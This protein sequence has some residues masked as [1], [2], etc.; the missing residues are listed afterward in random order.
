MN[1]QVKYEKNRIDRLASAL[2]ER[3]PMA[4]GP[5]DGLGKL[6]ELD[7]PTESP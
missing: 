5:D 3:P 7:Y 2:R 1:K 6:I 4:L